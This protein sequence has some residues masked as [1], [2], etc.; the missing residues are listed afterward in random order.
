MARRNLRVLLLSFLVCLVCAPKVSRSTRILWY[1]IRQIESRYL[2]PI[3]QRQLFEGDDRDDDGPGR[4][5]GL[6][7]PAIL[8][9]FNEQIDR[10]FG[11]IGIEIASIRGRST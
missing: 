2:A 5:F 4:L 1:A 11:G 10:E 7:S 9:D 8:E 3:E 6:H